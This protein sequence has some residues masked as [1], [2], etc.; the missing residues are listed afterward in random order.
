MDLQ[1]TT[2]GFSKSMG[3]KTTHGFENK[4]VYKII[5]VN[6]LKF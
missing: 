2:H 4:M 5:Q 1:K 6:I 3:R